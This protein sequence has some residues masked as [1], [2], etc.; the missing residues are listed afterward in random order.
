[1]FG[2]S[3]TFVNNASDAWLG[4][5]PGRIVT[6]CDICEPV[7]DEGSNT[8]VHQVWN[9]DYRNMAVSRD[10]FT[11]VGFLP[12]VVTEHPPQDTRNFARISEFY[13]SNHIQM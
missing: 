7:G 6:A 1:M 12:S 5:A 10:T 3:Q 8:K 11:G 13:I 9:S 2:S 4:R